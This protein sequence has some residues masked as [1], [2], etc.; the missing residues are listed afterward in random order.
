MRYVRR[1]SLPCFASL[2][3][4]GK[5]V[6]TESEAVYEQIEPWIQWVTVHTGRP[7]SD[8]RIFR[9]GDAVGSGLDQIWEVLERKGLTVGAVCPINAENRLRSPAFFLPDPWTATKVSGDKTLER[10]HRA[11]VEAVGTNAEG[12]IS[13]RSAF[14]L[15]NGFVSHVPSNRWFSYA[16]LVAKSMRR[17]WLKAVFL[18]ELLADLFLSLLRKTRPHFASLFLNAAAH[19][20]HHYMFNSAVY[21]GSQRNPDWY[22]P[23]GEDP[24]LDVYSSYDRALGRIMAAF[25]DARFLIATGLHQD[26]HPEETYYWRLKN[27]ADFLS[28]AGWISQTS[29]R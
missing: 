17:P 25:P 24:L 19:I 27:H 11:I 23:P 15:L 3:A 16:S 5:V 28:A 18:D 9:L 8:H 21:Q 2:L 22:V 7:F 14:A 13:M 12:R 29:M 6:T 10:L 26:P 4:R 20:Q 1:G